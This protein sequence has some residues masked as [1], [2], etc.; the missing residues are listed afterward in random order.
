MSPVDNTIARPGLA[1]LLTWLESRNRHAAGVIRSK[2]IGDVALNALNDLSVG[3]D[4]LWTRPWNRSVRR[5]IILFVL[6]Q[7]KTP[8]IFWMDFDKIFS[9]T[10]GE[11]KGARNWLAFVANELFNEPVVPFA[12]SDFDPEG[13]LLAQAELDGIV[14]RA[15]RKAAADLAGFRKEKWSDT[16][17]PGERVYECGMPL[18]RLLIQADTPPIWTDQAQTSVRSWWGWGGLDERAL[19]KIAEAVGLDAT[20]LNAERLDR[21]L[22]WRAVPSKD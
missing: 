19:R 2:P 9:L 20:G 16:F 13:R 21:I 7:E 17:A 10:Q 18:C 3:L 4:P 5:A 15:E 1:P 12:D 11:M 14:E 22:S 8:T 6:H